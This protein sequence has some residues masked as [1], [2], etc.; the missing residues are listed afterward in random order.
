MALRTLVAAGTA[1]CSS[2]GNSAECHLSSLAYTQ[3][4]HRFA[5]IGIR[6]SS[7]T[8]G[9][10]RLSTRMHSL[11]HKRA[12]AEAVVVAMPIAAAGAVKGVAWA[13]LVGWVAVAEM[14]WVNVRT[15]SH[16]HCNRSPCRRC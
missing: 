12:L 7:C 6:T 15:W 16:S 4:T 9:C 5:H 8:G 11:A 1:D 2:E 14:D 10:A 13:V 3:A